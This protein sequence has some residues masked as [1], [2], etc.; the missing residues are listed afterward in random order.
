MRLHKTSDGRIIPI[1]MGCFGCKHAWATFTF[2]GK[3][4]EV[5]CKKLDIFTPERSVCAYNERN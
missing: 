3:K 5:K 1:R 4:M 2:V